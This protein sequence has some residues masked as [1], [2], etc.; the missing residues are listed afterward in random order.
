MLVKYSA[1]KIIP[2]TTYSKFSTAE[3]TGVNDENSII[4]ES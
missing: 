1:A 4:K 2:S 3:I